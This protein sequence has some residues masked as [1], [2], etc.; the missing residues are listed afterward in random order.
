[1]SRI[2]H[3]SADYPDPLAPAKTRAVSNLLAMIGEHDHR[4]VSMNRVHW[5]TPP[6]ALGFADAAGAAHRALVY[7]A[8]GKGL[9]LRRYLARV[10]D[11]IAEDCAAAGFAPDV[12]HAHK[13]TIEGFVGQAL[14]A[15]WG[16]K[17]IVSVQG[18]TDQKIAGARRDLRPALG[19]IWRAADVAFPFAPWAFDAM[20]GLLGAR[21]APTYALPC[22]TGGDAILTPEVG[23]P[24]VLTACNLKDY[25]NKNLEALIRAVGRLGDEIP[26]LR[27]E[28]MGGGDP[29]AYAR[30]QATA[31]G[32][33]PGRVSFLGAV[34]H[35]EVQGRFHDAAAFAL[36]SH[37]ESYGM[38][39]AEALM[40]GAPCLIPRGRGVDGYFADGS[41]VL[42]ADPGDESAIAA[43][44]R[45][46]VIEQADFKQRLQALGAGGGLKFMQRDA[47][48]GAYRHGLAV[49]LGGAA[50]E[51]AADAGVVRLA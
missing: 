48:A 28:I 4:V 36:V 46:L 24:V 8:P 13:L 43:G 3:V 35:A 25:A 19:A 5:R 23:G 33:A 45:R 12:V 14:A 40:A 37:R 22:P 27:L 21:T 39:F 2:L 32:A 49:A 15:R 1:M 16:A 17:L 18:N 6:T 42:A 31:A 30:L 34:P 10:A 38:V 29:A 20:N 11:W 50:P 7:G 26:D 51:P 41:V 47:I 44:L 9:F